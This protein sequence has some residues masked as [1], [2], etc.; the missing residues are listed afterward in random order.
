MTRE[1]AGSQVGASRCSATT[2]NLQNMKVII[3][4]ELHEN[5]I[6]KLIMKKGTVVIGRKHQ[7]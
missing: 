7:Q 2:R 6:T 1:Q 3:R 4:S 5:N